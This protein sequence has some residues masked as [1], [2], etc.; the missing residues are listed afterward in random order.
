MDIPLLLGSHPSR[1]AGPKSLPAGSSLTTRL[2][3]ATQRLTTM[4]DRSP[5]TLSPG[6]TVY[7]FQLVC[8][9]ATNCRLRTLCRRLSELLTDWLGPFVL[10]VFPWCGPSGK[11][12][13][14]NFFIV[15][16]S[17]CTWTH[18]EHCSQQYLPWLSCMAWC[19][20]LLHHCL[21]CH[22]LVIYVSSG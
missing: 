4:G 7:D 21:L 8:L 1:L 22:N 9:P 2:G 18:R 20:P 11:C 14:Y 16:I 12:C 6:V 3:I 5:P 10:M 13:F 17:L 19:I 15:L